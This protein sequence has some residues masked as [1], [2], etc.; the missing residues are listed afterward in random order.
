MNFC[1]VT[2]TLLTKIYNIGSIFSFILPDNNAAATQKHILIF[3]FMMTVMN[4]CPRIL[5]GLIVYHKQTY[6]ILTDKVF[7]LMCYK[8]HG[9]SMKL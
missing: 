7:T 1:T 3:H 9:D 4:H 5:G 8:L 2:I 6:K